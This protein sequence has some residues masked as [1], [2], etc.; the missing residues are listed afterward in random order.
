MLKWEQKSRERKIYYQAFS[1]KFNLHFKPPSKDTCS[2]CDKLFQKISAETDEKKTADLKAEREL[3]L[4][5]AEQ[6]RAELKND[7]AEAS[8]DKKYD[9]TFDLQKALPFPK[10][11]TS[12]AYYKRNLYVY[13]F[14]I[15]CFNNNRF[16]IYDTRSLIP[17]Q[18][19]QIR[20]NRESK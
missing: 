14:G 5:W 7:A 15:H 16:K 13:N 9:C 4:R 20:Y 18:W 2:N 12:I 17:S 19:Y 3:H 11:T 10:L 1:Q 8:Q 6:A